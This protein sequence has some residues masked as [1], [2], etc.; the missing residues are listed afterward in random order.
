MYREKIIDI[1]T[2]EETFRDYTGQEIEEVK[3]TEALAK[4]IAEKAKEVAD[5][6]QAILLKLGLTEEEA[7]LL[8]GGN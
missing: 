1:N 3:K 4:E 5:A 8:L 2:G 6:R 7:K